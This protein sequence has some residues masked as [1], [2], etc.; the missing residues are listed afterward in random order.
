MCSNFKAVSMRPFAGKAAVQPRAL[1]VKRLKHA[2]PHASVCLP[3]NE[4]GAE[5]EVE[6]YRR[7][8]E[9]SGAVSRVGA[10]T[11]LQYDI[12][13]AAHECTPGPCAPL[14][15]SLCYGPTGRGLQAERDIPAWLPRPVLS[16]P[17]AHT[18]CVS[19]QGRKDAVSLEA[20]QVRVVRCRLSYTLQLVDIALKPVTNPDPQPP[21]TC[22]PRTPMVLGCQMTCVNLCSPASVP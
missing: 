18:L 4:T 11:M 8:V 2:V 7:C 21:P 1:R 12:A 15:V 5:Q 10:L 14:Q 13:I 20:W 22:G 9:Q 3:A 6:A 16:V 17:M 19:E